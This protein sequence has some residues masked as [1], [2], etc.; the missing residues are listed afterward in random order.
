VEDNADL[1]LGY[2]NAIGLFEASWDLP[3]SYQDLE[4]MGRKGSLYM[5]NG[6][7]KEQMGKEPESA[8]SIA[9][10]PA[11]ESEPVRFMVSRMRSG[12]PVD[13]LTAL[14]INVDVV[15]IIDAAKA[16]VREG[17]PIAL[18]VR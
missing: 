12:R 15:A 18:P 11:G 7:V 5:K 16:S 4:V 9:P 2:K 14:D 17:K 6:S 13:G 8:A 1:V 10:L 3:R